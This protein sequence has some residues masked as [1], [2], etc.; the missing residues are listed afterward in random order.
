MNQSHHDPHNSQTSDD[1]LSVAIALLSVIVCSGAIGW[2]LYDAST[3]KCPWEVLRQPPSVREL[4]E[5]ETPE[6]DGKV[7]KVDSTLRNSDEIKRHFEGKI[8]EVTEEAARNLDCRTSE[9]D[10]QI[11]ELEEM[12]GQLE[13]KIRHLLENPKHFTDEDVY[14]YR[15]EH[16]R[17]EGS[18]SFFIEWLRVMPELYDVTP[19]F[20]I[21]RP[22][23]EA[24][25]SAI[26]KRTSDIHSG[27]LWQGAQHVVREK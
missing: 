14:E 3:D 7:R 9:V 18:N 13:E 15:Q 20:N 4:E 21:I 2:M 27:A 5:E 22:Q 26:K 25:M 19:Y 16:C 10:M 12:T 23:L 6:R 17:I 1:S 24:R 8:R 11:R